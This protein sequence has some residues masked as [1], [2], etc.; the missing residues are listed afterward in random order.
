MERCIEFC[1]SGTLSEMR[2][3][4]L[5]SNMVTNLSLSDMEV[6]FKAFPRR[7]YLPHALTVRSLWSLNRRLRQKGGKA[8]CTISLKIPISHYGR[9]YAEGKIR[10]MEG[11]HCGAVVYSSVPNW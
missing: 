5:A 8:R 1:I 4:T 11:W 3:L 7:C 6:G 9:T 10:A 2:L